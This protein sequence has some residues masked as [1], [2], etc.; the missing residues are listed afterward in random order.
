MG[1]RILVSSLMVLLALALA[2]TGATLLFSSQY[3]TMQAQDTDSVQEVLAELP[4]QLPSRPRRL[5]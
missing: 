3:D 5:R 1:K 2:F 4:A